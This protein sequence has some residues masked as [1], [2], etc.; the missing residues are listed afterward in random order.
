MNPSDLPQVKP[1][2]Q[3]WHTY[4]RQWQ[5]LFDLALRLANLR[6]GPGL[7][8]STRGRFTTIRL[9]DDVQ[10]PRPN[11]RRVAVVAFANTEETTDDE[12]KVT[13]AERKLLVREVRYASK[14]PREGEYEWHGPEMHAFP[15][16]GHTLDDLAS[17]AWGT[18]TPTVATPILT[19]RRIDEFWYLETAASVERS[20]VLRAFLDDNPASQFVTVQEVRPEI[21]N[22]TW[23]GKMVAR[24]EAITANCW[25]NTWAELYKPFLWEAAEIDNRATILPMI[26]IGSVWWVKQRPKIGVLRRKGPVRLL[27]CSTVS[28]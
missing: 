28:P 7:Q 26:M 2:T 11:V 4:A 27:D 22:G 6:V 5:N 15:A 10:K 8:L 18:D 9:I 12:G 16:V 24:G 1:G 19:V 23:T 17:F 3:W 14:P 21:K 25:P 13:P 20:V